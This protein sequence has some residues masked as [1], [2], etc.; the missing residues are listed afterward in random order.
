MRIWN[1]NSTPPKNDRTTRKGGRRKEKM[2]MISREEEDRFLVGCFCVSCISTS[3]RESVVRTTY[4]A[5]TIP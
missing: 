5:S 1:P 4:N 3:L 2:K